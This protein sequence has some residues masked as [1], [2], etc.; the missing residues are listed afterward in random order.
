MASLKTAVFS[1]RAEAFDTPQN[2]RAI[3]G[4]FHELCA[5]RGLI[6]V[7]S[8]LEQRFDKATESLTQ[9]RQR[10]RVSLM[11]S[12]RSQLSAAVAIEAGPLRGAVLRHGDLMGRRSVNG[13]RR[14]APR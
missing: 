14:P 8:R 4:W 13:A 11:L 2:Q 7:T 5:Q 6:R 1:S 12:I 9:R 3:A 10:D